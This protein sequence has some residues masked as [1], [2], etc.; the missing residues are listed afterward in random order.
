MRVSKYSI[1]DAD[2]IQPSCMS[3]N[4]LSI[5]IYCSDVKNALDK[6]R[7]ILDIKHL[8]ALVLGWYDV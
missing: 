3:I 2:F 7:E 5:N 4:H 8:Q 6:G 1:S